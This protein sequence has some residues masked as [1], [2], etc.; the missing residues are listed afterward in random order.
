MPDC[1]CHAHHWRLRPACAGVS[2]LPVRDSEGAAEL[3][4][5]A[6]AARAV[7]STAMNAT[8]SRSHSVFMLYISGAHAPSATGCRARCAW[9]T[10][11][12]GAAQPGPARGHAHAAMH[13]W[14]EEWCSGALAGSTPCAASFGLPA[15]MHASNAAAAAS[16]LVAYV[17]S[18]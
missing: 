9:W 2:R 14:A 11:P 17:T 10:W 16:R 4:R 6:A 18:F 15:C 5:R 3:I 12:E 13:C 7:E 1:V 8:S